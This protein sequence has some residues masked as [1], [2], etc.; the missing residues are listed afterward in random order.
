ME[1]ENSP[2]G[3]EPETKE[4]DKPISIVEEARL[5][6]DD[7]KK[8]KEELRAERE[9][10]ERLKSEN[11]LSGNTGGMVEPK[12]VSPE[13]KKVTNAKE[14]FKDTALGDAITKTNE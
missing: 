2:E 4:P 5:L 1:K 3:K 11:I 7:I 8:E 13:E 12:D 9:K 6:R 14:F 10:I